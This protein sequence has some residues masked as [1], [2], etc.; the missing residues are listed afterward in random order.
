[1]LNFFFHLSTSSVEILC[2]IKIDSYIAISFRFSSS[3]ASTWICRLEFMV[4]TRSNSRFA[5][6]RDR[7]NCRVDGLYFRLNIIP[8]TFRFYFF[9]NIHPKM[10]DMPDE[11]CND[12]DHH[13]VPSPC[14]P[15]PA[16]YYYGIYRSC[17]GTGWLPHTGHIQPISLAPYPLIP[18]ESYSKF[19]GVS[20]NYIYDTE[21]E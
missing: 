18:R 4:L 2:F 14:H 19:Y 16:S 11:G 8:Y 21:N 15:T 12:R 7:D 9:G 5:S 17:Y 1:M 3:F 13:R 20:Y 6:L 10:P